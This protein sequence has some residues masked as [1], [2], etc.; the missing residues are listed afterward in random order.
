MGLLARTQIVSKH[1]ALPEVSGAH[2]PGAI[3]P[4]VS[5]C[6]RWHPLLS[7]TA[8]LCSPSLRWSSEQPYLFCLPVRPKEGLGVQPLPCLPAGLLAP[9][10]LPVACVR[11]SAS[12]RELCYCWQRSDLLFSG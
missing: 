3:C 1:V 7:P 8:M 11:V 10:P 9:A 6:N 4:A 2:L 5:G 12:T